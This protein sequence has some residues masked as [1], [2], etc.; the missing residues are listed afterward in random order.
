MKENGALRASIISLAEARGAY[1]IVSSKGSVS[2]TA[3]K[4][5]KNA[6]I[7]ALADTPSAA[8]LHVDF[9][10]RRRIASWVNQHPGLIPWV[11]SRIG[12]PLAG[13]RPYEDWSSSPSVADESYFT[14]DHIRLVGKHFKETGGINAVGGINKLREILSKPKGAIRLVGLSGVGKTR[15]AQALFDKTIGENA[16]NS[17]LAVYTDLAEGPDPVPLELLGRIQNLGQKC[18]LIVDNCGVELH[19]K[20]VARMKN[21]QTDI[22]ILTIEYD[23]SDDEPESTDTFKL[24]PAS[25]NIIEKIIERRYPHLTGPEIRTISEFSEGNSRVAL[26]LAET[27]KE[28]EALVNLQD[29]KLIKRLFQQNHE[30]NPALLRAAKVCA[31]VYSFD[32]ETLEGD[33]AELPILAALAE[34]SVSEMHAHVAELCRRQ[35]VQKHSKWRALL[36]HALAH[37]LAKQALQDI[38]LEILKKKFTDIAP[39][40]MFKSFS[41]RLGCL[42]DSPQA[43]AIMEGWLAEGGRL[44]EIEKLDHAGMI[45]L[46]N[47]AP[48]NPDAVLKS[49]QK[50]IERTDALFDAQYSHRSEIISLLRS[51]A[52]EEKSFNEAVALIAEFTGPGAESNNMD[53]AINVFKSLFYIYLSGTHAPAEQRTK[54]LKNL[55]QSQYKNYHAQVMSALDAMLEC[56]HFSSSY[57]FEFG[58]HKSV[59]KK[60][61]G[62]DS[63]DHEMDHRHVDHRLTA[64]RE[65]FVVFAQPAVFSKPA[66]GA[67]HHPSFW[68]EHKAFGLIRAL[69]DLQAN[70]TVRTKPEQPRGQGNPYTR[71]R[72]KSNAVE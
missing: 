68:Q 40:R 56:V 27:S 24:E 18:I 57:G 42:H 15:L 31:L 55:A 22:S 14:D 37:K 45:I 51:L 7:E 52:Y 47:L 29:S 3:L 8:G 54:F 43:Q 30:E 28:G 58:T 6:M 63:T 17:D 61:F 48:I 1:I 26:A 2:D 65:V 25:S 59:S 38:P 12:L 23:I 70:P 36:P 39:E 4:N 72:P 60:C 11:R 66:E 64:R 32:G 46:K 13:W 62:L 21:I 69:D 5:R 9:Y 34:Q 67:F 50:T 49:I 35:P 71:Y 16:L 19:R 53:D 20:L 44:A 41:R 10:D 33:E